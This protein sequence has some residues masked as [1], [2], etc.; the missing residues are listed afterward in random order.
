MAKKH[1]WMRHYNLVNACNRQAKWK[2][3]IVPQKPQ[4]HTFA[5]AVTKL[6]EDG[7]PASLV[8]DQPKLVLAPTEVDAKIKVLA[9]LAK[10]GVYDPDAPE[11]GVQ[12]V[13]FGG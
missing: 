13:P 4:L 8:E 7:N 11:V 5:F 10:E 6:D 1:G 9:R 2:E 12:L 3:G